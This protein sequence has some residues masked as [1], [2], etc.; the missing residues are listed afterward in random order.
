MSPAERQAAAERVLILLEPKDAHEEKCSARSRS[1]S[2]SCYLARNA[3]TRAAAL[4]DAGLLCA[5]VEAT[6]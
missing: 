2:C 5:L 4:D 6:T 3:R 1:E